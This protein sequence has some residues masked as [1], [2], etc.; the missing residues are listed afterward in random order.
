[1]VGLL[2][3][4]IGEGDE[5]QIKKM[6]KLFYDTALF[7]DNTVDSLLKE[8]ALIDVADKK[9]TYIDFHKLVKF[10]E[11]ALQ[12]YAKE[13][14]AYSIELN[15]TTDVPL[16]SQEEAIASIMR[17][18]IQNAYKYRRKE[19]V[20]EIKISI[21]NLANMEGV[22]LCIEDNGIGIE[23]KAQ[24]HIFELGSRFTSQKSTGYGLYFV[25]KAV[26]K[27]NGTIRIDSTLGKGTCFSIKLP[28]L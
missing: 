26:E 14:V 15:D 27:I 18:L 6:S 21:H 4:L 5:K 17:N 3:H 19:V 23:S 10:N 11:K 25:K 1:M 22:E 7:L 12:L 24:Q 20:L 16:Y 13:T 8:S 2:E 9:E 28:N